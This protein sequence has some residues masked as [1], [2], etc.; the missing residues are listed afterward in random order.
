[1]YSETLVASVIISS[2]EDSSLS[3]SG[4]IATV[5]QA[6]KDECVE[7]DDG[8]KLELGEFITIQWEEDGVDRL[9]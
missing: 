6:V 4:T 9:D 5:P 8:N 1:L 2:R 7:I 3:E